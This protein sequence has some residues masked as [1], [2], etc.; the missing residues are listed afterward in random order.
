VSWLIKTWERL[1]RVA[2]APSRHQINER[3]A[4]GVGI[5]IELGASL[6]VVADDLKRPALL[7]I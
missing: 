3:N 7:I 2:E 4:A 5:D 6:H 1:K